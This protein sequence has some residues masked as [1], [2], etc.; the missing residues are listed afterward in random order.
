[1]PLMFPFHGRHYAGYPGCKQPLCKA[2]APLKYVLSVTGAQ[3]LTNHLQDALQDL[4][5]VR[6]QENDLLK[7][8][9]DLC[10]QELEDQ[11]AELER[12]FQL[13]VR[14]SIPKH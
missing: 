3:R 2:C 5:A 12:S 10:H 9:V 4:S 8:R 1:M 14:Q 13:K 11:I 7:R 6:Q